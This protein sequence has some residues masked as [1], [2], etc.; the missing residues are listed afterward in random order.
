M[1][2]VKDLAQVAAV[3]QV[4]SLAWELPH[5][6]GVAKII[7][8]I[9]ISHSVCLIWEV[10]AFKSTSRVTLS[11]GNIRTVVICDCN[12]SEGWQ[13]FGRFNPHFLSSHI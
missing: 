7:N 6:L 1:Q 13:V 10:L 9:E 8:E 2:Q 4:Q 11:N 5:A 12:F 3:A